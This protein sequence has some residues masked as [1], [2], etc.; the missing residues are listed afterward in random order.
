[1]KNKKRRIKVILFFLV[2]FMFIFINNTSLFTKERTGQPL[3]LAHRG[4]ARTFPMDGIDADTCTAS[5]IYEPE[6]RY[7]ENTIPSMRAAFDAGADMVELDIKPTK[8][9]QFTVFHD[10]TLG[11]R[12]NVQGM[13]KDY[14]MEELKNIDI[15]Y[16]YTADQ[17]ATHPF[18]GKGVGLMP[19]L[20][21]TLSAFPN[22]SFLIH[23]KSSDSEEGAQLADD[24]LRLSEKRLSRITVYG[25]DA[26]VSTLK[27]RLPDL[28]VMSMATLKNCLVSYTGAGWTGYI[29]SVCRNTQLH[30][31]E[32]YARF[33]WGWPDKFLNRMDSVDTRVIVVA[34][35]GGWPEGFD[36]ENDLQRLPADYSGGLW[37]NRI[38]LIAP[39]LKIE[40]IP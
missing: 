37:T 20:E 16:G 5:R 15:G 26:P 34:G 13:V 36:S 22:G 12:T 3:L 23:I 2:L 39:K 27:A 30:I 4:L 29:P 9:G 35:N 11:C 7:L 40:Q 21:E 24:L 6:H 18:R 1:M 19:S 32:K 33:L 10:W 38:D 31:P 17:G 28:R 25:D 14:T 8:D